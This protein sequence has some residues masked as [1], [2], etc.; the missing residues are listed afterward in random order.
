[1]ETPTNQ[2][3]RLA[4]LEGNELGTKRRRKRRKK[5]EEVKIL[6]F[7]LS[8]SIC[9]INLVTGSTTAS[10]KTLNK[11]GEG[12][13][14]EISHSVTP[15]D[16]SSRRPAH[17]RPSPSRSSVFVGSDLIRDFVV[18]ND[19]IRDKKKKK[20]DGKGGERI[21]KGS[22]SSSSLHKK[23]QQYHPHDHHHHHHF[24][25][26]SSSSSH[27]RFLY[28]MT[29]KKKGGKIVPHSSPPLLRNEGPKDWIGTRR[30]EEALKREKMEERMMNKYQSYDE[31]RAPGSTR[32]MD[33]RKYSNHDLLS[34]HNNNDNQNHS[35]SSF[36]SKNMYSSHGS[37]LNSVPFIQSPLLSSSLSLIRKRV[38]RGEAQND[39]QQNIPNHDLDQG[40]H[41]HHRSRVHNHN[42]NLNRHRHKR[43]RH[44]A[45]EST[46]K[47][48]FFDT[49]TKNFR[50]SILSDV[51]YKKIQE[52][53]KSVHTNTQ[54]YSNI[55]SSMI[56][57][58]S[59]SLPLQ[60]SLSSSSCPSV[61]TCRWK[62]GKKTAN[63]E[64]Q[65]LKSIPANIDPETQ[66]LDL[67][68]NNFEREH[69]EY[70]AHQTVLSNR[71]FYNLNLNNLQRIYL[72]R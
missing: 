7:L 41:H 9:I 64:S 16:D 72:S 48:T 14:G 26:H 12:K 51:P 44:D 50:D 62:S 31:L 45:D 15:N 69:S 71:I 13:E 27:P 56:S 36:P 34:K 68:R 28:L 1:M 46:D 10:F 6:F 17:Q 58:E 57:H 2:V 23:Y 21:E 54:T 24:L 47:R 11:M 35:M 42:H 65:S 4:S 18:I 61:C 39:E 25:S 32:F 67:S 43:K 22:S 55:K 59:S 53:T 19:S 29:S 63:C 30:K 8:I 38:K 70:S 37:N 66:I 5:M 3:K 60:L 49:N 40:L 52:D 33:K 20:K